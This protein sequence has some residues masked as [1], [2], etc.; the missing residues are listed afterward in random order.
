MPNPKAA[1]VETEYRFVIVHLGSDVVQPTKDQPEND[2]EAREWL[3]EMRTND[4]EC[5]YECRKIESVT[6]NL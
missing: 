2:Q 4:P 1:I 5:Q 3:A 6:T